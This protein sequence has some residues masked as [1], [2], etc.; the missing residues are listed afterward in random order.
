MCLL[1]PA[2]LTNVHVFGSGLNKS[3]TAKIERVQQA[4]SGYIL[5]TRD[6]SYCKRLTQLRIMPLKCRRDVSDVSKCNTTAF[7]RVYFNRVTQM[8]NALALSVRSS[9]SMYRFLSRLTS[10]IINVELPPL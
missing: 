4:A 6:L 10:H 2:P 7:S 8:W 1:C 5:D 9:S 3:E